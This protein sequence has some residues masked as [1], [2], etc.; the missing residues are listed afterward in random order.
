MNSYVALIVA[1]VTEVVGTSSLKASDGFTRLGPS[2]LVVAGYSFAFFFRS[3]AVRII[4]LGIV[5][6]LWS[7]LG[8]ALIALVGWL[9][10]K[11]PLDAPAL[12]GIALIITGCV[13]L[14]IFSK[15]CAH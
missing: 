11:Q 1:I 10:L 9:V 12:L 15:A 8:S 13:V 5:Y 2:L 4:P 7:G 6:A 14:N 3:I